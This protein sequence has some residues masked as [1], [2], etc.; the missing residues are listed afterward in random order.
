M[1]QRPASL[2]GALIALTPHKQNFKATCPLAIML[3]GLCG[4]RSVELGPAWPAA[5]STTSHRPGSGWV[6]EEGWQEG[7]EQLGKGRV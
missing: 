1:A 4:P 2:R 3:R 5:A 6:E 7:Q